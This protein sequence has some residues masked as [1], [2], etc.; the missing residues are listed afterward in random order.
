MFFLSVF[1]TKENI[2]RV[3]DSARST[4]RM[5][6]LLK[7]VFLSLLFLLFHLGWKNKTNK[8]ET[9]T[10]KWHHVTQKRHYKEEAEI[11]SM[12]WKISWNDV[13]LVSGERSGR[14]GGAAGGKFGSRLSI[15]RNSITVRRKIDERIYIYSSWLRQPHNLRRLPAPTLSFWG[16]R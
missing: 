1:P 6:L 13:V 4:S 16:N 8:H 10:N 12:T 9:K 11:A 15:G 2:Q 7:C 5:F 3:V 14:S